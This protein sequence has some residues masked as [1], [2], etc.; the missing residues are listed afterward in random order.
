MIHPMGT[1]MTEEKKKTH[2]GTWLVLILIVGIG[3]TYNQNVV[4]EADQRREMA[5]QLERAVAAKKVMIGMS[6]DQ[7]I[8]AW[9]KPQKINSTTT[10]RGTR[11]QW[12][13]PTHS[14]IYFDEDEKLT[15]IQN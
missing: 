5:P 12:I 2:P 3:Y 13:Y 14:Y 1:L 11:E 6:K 7:A 8:R 10:S 4:R 9:G 15:T